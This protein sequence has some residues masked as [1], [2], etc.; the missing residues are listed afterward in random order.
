METLKIE[1]ANTSYPVYLG[2]DVLKQLPAFLNEHFPSSRTLL[3]ITDETVAKLY[4]TPF[5]NIL[6]ETGMEILVKTVPSGE[7]AKTFDVYYECQTFALENKLNRK[8]LV[9]A[10]GGGAVGDLAGFVAATFMRGIPFIQ[11]PTTIL[12]HDSAVGGKVAIN[13]PAGKNMIG[14]F[15]QPRA[16]FYDT[17]CLSSLPAKE[18]RS[19]FAEIIKE[20]IIQEPEFLKWLMAAVDHLGNIDQE[21]LVSAIESGIK[22]KGSIV[23]QDELENGVRAYLNFGHTLGHALENTLGYGRITHGEGVMTGMIFAL[24]LSIKYTGLDFDLDAFTEW[25][26][27][28]GYTISLPD[29]VQHEDLLAAMKKDKKTTGDQA[30]FVLLKEIGEPVIKEISDKNILTELSYMAENG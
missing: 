15:Y 20:A 17:E 27:K 4:L 11:I 24:R 29:T 10:F 3:L 7:K 19:G 26:K 22:I 28:L 21:S 14:A 18:I 8:S 5:L 12:A 2:R 1:T 25:V 9:L 16:V 23:K 6:K 13:H 30:A